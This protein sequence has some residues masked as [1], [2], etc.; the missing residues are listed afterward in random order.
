MIQIS[1]NHNITNRTAVEEAFRETNQIMGLEFTKAI[2]D[3]IWNWLD[4]ANRDIVDTGRLR[5][6]YD[7]TLVDP[8]TYE[9]TW[10]VDYAVAAHEGARLRN[11]AN[12]PARPW[13]TYALR[14]KDFADVFARLAAAKAAQ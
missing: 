11:G 14:Q 3:N 9:H 13:T 12:I 2:T 10:A 4:G 6:S 7:M 5:D 8:D 1:W